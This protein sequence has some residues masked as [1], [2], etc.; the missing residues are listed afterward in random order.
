MNTRTHFKSRPGSLALLLSGSLALGG[1][2]VGLDFFRP[3][4][5]KA[6]V[7]TAQPQAGQTLATPTQPL[8]QAQ[9]LT[10]AQSIPADW[11]TGFG[12]DKLDTLI[13]QALR[14]SP[15]LVEA[16]AKL[17]QAEQNYAA[18]AG[19]S[20][21]PQVDSTLGA[22]RTH[23]SDS[24]FGLQGK[25]HSYNLYNVGVAVS[26][27]LDVFG[28]NRRALEALAAQADYQRYQSDAARL[29]LAANIVTAAMTQA[30]LAAQIEA[31]AAILAAQQKQVDIAHTRFEL[32]AIA[33][34]DEYTL[35]TQLEQ[36]RASIPPLRNQIEQTGHLLATLS[37]QE[38]GAAE[39]P[40]FTLADFQLP[41]AL[42][43]IVPSA[44]VRQRP[45]IQAAEALLHTATAQYGV[46]VA[47]AYPKI[48]LSANVGTQ[49]LVASSLFGPGSLVW[50]LGGQLL[51]PLF[52]GGLKAGTNAAQAGV[53]AAAA[54]YR[55]T[56]LNA[57]RNVADVLRALDNDAQTLQAQSAADAAAQAAQ[58]IVQQQYQLGGASYLQLLVAQQQAQQTR[59]SLLAAQTQ[60]LTTT[61][62]FY[63][64]MGGGVTQDQEQHD[65]PVANK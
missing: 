39:I 14:A 30:R 32:G 17:R 55:D 28:G 18:Q 49:A 45:D 2:T 53:D 3:S 9:A 42:P 41:T 21:Y 35:R 36:T 13:D 20:L 64:A 44:L 19:S 7:Y 46:A 37:G 4:P 15:T 29:T 31:T 8:G 12:S 22:Q 5:P 56:V 54:N 51:Q 50:G 24:N 63:Q 59:I 60:R 25:G 6:E 34:G 16:Q 47:D 38:P 1:C 27:Q 33:R 52:N 40:Q 58:K 57:L 11:W 43:L 62:A 10:P 23:T 61:A 26:Y 65:Q 48:N